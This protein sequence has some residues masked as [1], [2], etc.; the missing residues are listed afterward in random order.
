MLT[1]LTFISSL[2]IAAPSSPVKWKLQAHRMNDGLVRIDIRTEVEEGWH[3]Y[4]TTLPSDEGPIATS[5]RFK[6]SDA[7]TLIGELQEPTPTEVFDPNFSM[8]VRYHEGSPAFEQ[9]V[10]PS[11]PG[12]FVVEGEVEYMV[13]NDKTCLPP[14]EVPFKLRVESM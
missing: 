1:L 11:K 6:P 9:A 10:K 2:I 12:A 3:I 14:I 8:V 5:I 4:A 7:F 13:C